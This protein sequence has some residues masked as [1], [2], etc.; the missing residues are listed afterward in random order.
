MVLI[1]NA[2][3][4]TLFWKVIMQ[5]ALFSY[6]EG[7]ADA[8]AYA[9]A[10]AYLYSR[11]PMFS[12][13]GSSAYKKDLTN[14]LALLEPLGNPQ[15]RFKS[16][17]VA[18]TNGKGSTSSM[19]ASILMEAGYK[20]GLYT[21]PHLR[22]FTERMRINGRDIPEKA[23]A[24]FV[25]RMKPY[26][27]R[28]EPSFFE[29]TVAMC[30]DYFAREQVDIAVVEVGLG[31]R[32]DSTNVITPVLSV[33]TNISWDHADLLGDTLAEIAGEKAGI[34]KSG[35]PVVIG[36]SQPESGPVF[37][38]KSEA[39]QSP[40]VFADKRYHVVPLPES[41]AA[42][43]R[44]FGVTGLP[45]FET[46]ETLALDLSGV[47][48]R[49]NLATV[50]AAVDELRALGWEIPAEAVVRGLAHTM[51]NS[52]LRGRMQVL[53]QEPLTLCDTAHN[54][55]G[56]RE[57]MAQISALCQ[58]FGQQGGADTGQLRIV[59]GMVSDKDHGKILALFPK[60]AVYY[61]VKPD[62]PRGLEAEALREKAA[63][64]GLYGEVFNS[65][66]A[67][68]EA[69]KASANKNDVIFI[70]GSTFVVAEVV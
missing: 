26:I 63:D 53:A 21:S 51:R 57:V 1:I 40:I 54:E 65:V 58:R 20:T 49:H 36:E 56:I 9:E 60:H 61:F 32:L 50:L 5:Q 12:R 66:S 18:G 29:A 67:G 44:G 70:G 33:I 39:T 24:D 62:V 52:G 8:G 7:L 42:E 47:Y 45:A 11:L 43:G 13:I 14:T 30:F 19:L 48:Q 69:A 23:V 17:H 22:S 35:I 4:R 41:G 2:N 59:M 55:A 10:V 25:T 28:V 6:T 68:F 46:P 27:E 38:A 37:R 3:L 64:F 16:I 34:I 31:G 15:H